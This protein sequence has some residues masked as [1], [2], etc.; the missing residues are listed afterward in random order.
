MSQENQ[1]TPNVYRLVDSIL[2]R[3]AMCIWHHPI[4]WG[5]KQNKKAEERHI[6]SLSLLELGCLSSPALLL[7][8]PLDS[9]LSHMN[10]TTNI[11]GSPEIDP[12]LY[13]LLTYNKDGKVIQLRKDQKIKQCWN[14]W[15]SVWKNMNFNPHLRLY[16]KINLKQIMQKVK[17]KSDKVL[18]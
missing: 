8:R 6:H 10:Y 7:L 3:W 11:P 15:I 12:H 16:T 13:G 17:G 2:S 5:A 14:N 1:R 4:S 18:E 9:N